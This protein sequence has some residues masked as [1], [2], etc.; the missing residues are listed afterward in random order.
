MDDAGGWESYSNW[1]VRARGG[2]RLGH[3][4]RRTHPAGR[5]T[6]ESGPN[7]GALRAQNNERRGRLAGRR[8]VRRGVW[9]ASISAMYRPPTIAPTK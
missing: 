3:M 7:S 1:W 6:G 8:A 5:L 9:A 4:G 2:T